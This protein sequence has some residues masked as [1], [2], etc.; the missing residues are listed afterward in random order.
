M[1]GEDEAAHD[2]RHLDPTVGEEEGGSQ[3][4]VGSED[5]PVGSKSRELVGHRLTARMVGWVLWRRC[6]T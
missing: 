2:S 4:V 5:G 6:V 1:V 3:G